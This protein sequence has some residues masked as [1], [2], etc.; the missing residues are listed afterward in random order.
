MKKKYIE[1]FGCVMR[2]EIIKVSYTLLGLSSL[3]YCIMDEVDGI[4]RFLS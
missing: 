4:G 1:I 3:T 2:D